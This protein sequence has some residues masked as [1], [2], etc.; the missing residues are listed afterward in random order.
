MS[1][2]NCNIIYLDGGTTD[3]IHIT[4]RKY[5]QDDRRL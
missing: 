1:Q 4:N 3:P 5:D 2:T